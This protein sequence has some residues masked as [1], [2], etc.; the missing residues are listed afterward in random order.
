[1]KRLRNGIE[2]PDIGLGLGRLPAMCDEVADV[3]PRAAQLGYSLFDT[4]D[5]YKNE[6]EVGVAM[7]ACGHR[8]LIQTKVSNAQQ[9]AVGAT[10]AIRASLTKLHRQSIDVYLMHWPMPVIWR[11]TWQDMEELCHR[12]YCC[13]IGVCNFT[14]RHL[15][16][17]LGFAWIRPTINQIEVHPFFQQRELVAFC[18]EHGI[19]VQ[20]YSPLGAPYR[21]PKGRVLLEHPVIRDIA[22]RRERTPAQVALRWSIQRG[23][24]PIV[25]TQQ[26]GRLEENL[27][28]LWFT[29]PDDEMEAIDDLDCGWR[30]GYDP[31]TCDYSK[32]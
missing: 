18:Q 6:T 21:A 22:K 1:M 26:P 9:R 4:S 14:V 7:Q 29:L 16:S 15:E 20:A 19:L 23:H 17:L 24:L 31:N 11:Q 12:G 25:K 2:L 28:A 8:V 32:L 3:V 10:G 13:T 30:M 5:S 27:G